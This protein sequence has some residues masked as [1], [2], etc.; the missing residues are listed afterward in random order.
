MYARHD[1]LKMESLQKEIKRLQTTFRCKICKQL[2]T[3]TWCNADE[4]TCF[5][6]HRYSPLK[7]SRIMILRDM[8][9]CYIQSGSED[10]RQYYHDFDTYLNLW[11]KHHHIPET[12][13]EYEYILEKFKE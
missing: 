1:M 5:F 4:A 13:E 9:W 10:R 11:C 3:K 6:C 8:E 12:Q 2:Y 7:H